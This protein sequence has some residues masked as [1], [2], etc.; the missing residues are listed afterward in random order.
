M[1]NLGYGPVVI[2]KVDEVMLPEHHPLPAWKHGGSKRER[3]AAVNREI[4]RRDVLGEMTTSHG[5]CEG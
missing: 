2:E 3:F 5:K 4:R 1:P